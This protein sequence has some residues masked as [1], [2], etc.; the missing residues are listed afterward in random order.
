MMYVFEELLLVTAVQ[1]LK[2]NFAV[3]KM[4]RGTYK[5]MLGNSAWPRPDTEILFL[6]LQL[7]YQ[8]PGVVLL[9]LWITLFADPKCP[10]VH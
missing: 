2:Y 1:W 6:T 5:S 7:Q 9:F 10:E 8:G 4:R 3:T